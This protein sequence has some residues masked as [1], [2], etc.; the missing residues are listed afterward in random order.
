[1]QLDRRFFITTT[2]KAVLA[3]PFLFAGSQVAW[4][5]AIVYKKADLAE[6]KKNPSIA[7]LKYVADAK[8]SKARTA[9]KM[10][11]KAADQLCD[12]CNFYKEPGTLEGSKDKVG[13]CLMFQNQ[14]VH[15]AGWCNVWTKMAK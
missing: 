6:T 11:V 3:A 1:M 10:G 13:K 5:K 12:N 4:A 14:V 2:A 15:G 7:A 8:K 9:D